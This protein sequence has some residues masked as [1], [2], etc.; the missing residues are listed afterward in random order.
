MEWVQA[1]G[2][3]I[4][5]TGVDGAAGLGLVG[6]V[7]LA[8][9]VLFVLTLATGSRAS[10][11]GG[12]EGWQGSRGRPSRT[13][14]TPA[15]VFLPPAIESEGLP[16]GDRLSR[17]AEQLRA[18]EENGFERKPL[19]N[20]GEARLLRWLDEAAEA[21]GQGHRVMAQVAL[22]EVIVPRKDAGEAALGAIVAKRLDFVI[23]DARGMIV[24]AVE[25][26]GSGH[27]QGHA[28][29]RDAVKREA[30]RK[31]GV[32]LIETS[33]DTVEENLLREVRDLLGGGGRSPFDR[34]D[35]EGPRA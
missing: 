5:A 29:A 32:R 22:N 19:V 2:S 15:P 34:G 31:A 9:L 8:L 6:L 25:H 10:R 21:A 27:H 4:E 16:D 30:L 1:R 26:Q 18:V 35:T 23:F 3:P 20:R 7:L 13:V 28:F 12:R 14:R 24:A 33:P 11:S 17:G